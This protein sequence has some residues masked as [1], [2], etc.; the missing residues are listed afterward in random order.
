MP[1]RSPWIS[2][3]A[4]ACGGW[5]HDI[6]DPGR[7][8]PAKRD[9]PLV[10]R[11]QQG[12]AA[13]SRGAFRWR[14]APAPRSRVERRLVPDGRAGTFLA[15]RGLETQRARTSTPDR[16]EVRLAERR[17][18]PESCRAHFT[19]TGESPVTDRRKPPAGSRLREGER[20]G[21]GRRCPWLPPRLEELPPLT[22]LTLA[23]GGPIGGGGNTGGGGSGILVRVSDEM[24]RPYEPASP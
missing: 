11:A 24:T 23:T 15:A 7:P 14:R 3:K 6:G 9:P 16:E 18:I 2:N 1:S 21:E 8:G 19:I 12:D 5:C 10:G 22:E 13:K 17:R 4:G 20:S